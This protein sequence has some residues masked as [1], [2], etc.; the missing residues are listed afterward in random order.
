MNFNWMRNYVSLL[1]K[2]RLRKVDILIP[3][4]E[5]L[6]RHGCANSSLVLGEFFRTGYLLDM[7]GFECRKRCQLSGL[8]MKQVPDI[9]K[10]EMYLKRACRQGCLSAAYYLMP[11]YI[12][13]QEYEKAY[14]CAQ[15]SLPHLPRELRGCC[16]HALG[17]MFYNF[18]V[19]KNAKEIAIEYWRKSAYCG[20]GQAMYEL[21][22]LYM[23]GEN[24]RRSLRISQRYFK[25]CILTNNFCVARA[26][27]RLK[28]IEYEMNHKGQD[29]SGG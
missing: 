15:R 21:G 16:Y 8:V 23:F 17:Y 3:A 20:N 11:I 18:N 6:S 4:L 25:K 5:F 29:R 10:A 2:R 24:V 1:L 9:T 7:D 19:G 26:K 28:E 14:R 12:D 22:V 27:C 13:K